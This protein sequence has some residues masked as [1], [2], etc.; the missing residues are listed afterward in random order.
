VS[1]YSS[2]TGYPAV[3]SPVI[4]G[5]TA[6][7]GSV[8]ATNPVAST[9]IEPTDTTVTVVYSPTSNPPPPPSQQTVQVVYVDDETGGLTIQPAAGTRVSIN[10]L[11]GDPVGFTQ[12]EAEAGVPGNY[13][14]DSIDNINLFDDDP[15]TTQTITVHVSHHHTVSTIIVTRTVQYTGAG[16]ANPEPVSQQVVWYQDTDDVTGQVF[17][18]SA[19][20]HAEVPSPN[21]DGHGVDRER[22]EGTSAVAITTIPPQDT[23]ETVVYT[24]LANPTPTPTSTPTPTPTSTPTPTPTPQ[25]S[26]PG[27]ESLPVTGADGV[28]L[29][30][31][32][33]LAGI[34]GGLV[35]CLTARRRRHQ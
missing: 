24:P 6:Q 11:A 32:G 35:L 16:S 7:P 29:A 5:F 4:P 34:A 33:A 13:V 9:T 28:G 2:T 12:S 21:V 15:T 31:A 30:L 18:W 23:T 14:F 25:S 10:G 27:P 1:V 3:T 17:Y 26:S 20:G 8:P 22:V 19:E